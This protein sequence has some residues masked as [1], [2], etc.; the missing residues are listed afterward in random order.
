MSD[1]PS[2]AVSDIPEAEVAAAL[3]FAMDFM[4]EFEDDTEQQ[5]V[6]AALAKLRAARDQGYRL[7]RAA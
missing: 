4:G 6:A 7:I 2:I 3:T 1:Q 5:G